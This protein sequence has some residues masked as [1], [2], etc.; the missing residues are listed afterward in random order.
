MERFM[1]KELIFI[2]SAPS[3]AGKT[4]LVRKVMERLP[5]LRFSVSYTTRPPRAS[6]R[7]GQDYFFV[8]EEVFDQM[9][10][11][12]EF[13]ASGLKDMLHGVLSPRNLLIAAATLV[14]TAAFMFVDWHALLVKRR[15]SFNFHVF[16]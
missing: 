15:L 7:D 13:A 8:S 12:G 16:R 3:G 9:V 5:G 4:T 6:E 10:K 14:I 1:G 11:A 2:V